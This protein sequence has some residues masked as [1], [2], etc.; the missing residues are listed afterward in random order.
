MEIEKLFKVL[1]VGGTL[2]A[3]TGSM[4]NDI[5][6]LENTIKETTLTF[7]SVEDEKLC[8]ENEEGEFVAKEGLECCWGTSCS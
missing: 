2:I 4:A 3:S 8:V 5:L 7:C 6:E 1:V